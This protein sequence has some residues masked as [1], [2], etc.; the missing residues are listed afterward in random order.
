MTKP[1]D[2]SIR[3]GVDSR[4]F[5]G[6]AMLLLGKAV[7]QGC[8][9]L[10]NV[11]VA[12]I[13]GVENFGI[14]STF[15][16]TVS[17]F[18]ML[19]SLSVDRLLVQAEDGNDENF[20]ATAH[21]IQ[22]LR[23]FS[24]GLLIAICAG[25]MAGLFGVPQTAWAFRYLG[26]LPVLRGFAHLDNQRVQRNLTYGPSVLLD[27]AQQLIPT[28]LAWPIS[29]WTKD[30]SAMLWLVLLQGLIAALGSFAVADRPYRWHWDKRYVKRFLD[31]G[32]PLVANAILLFGIYQGDRFL[33]GTATKTLGS[34]AYSM[35]DLGIYA[36]ATSLTLTPMIAFSTI[37]SSL[38][39]PLFSGL[40]PDLHEFTKRYRTGIQ[41]VGLASGCFAV[42]LILAGGWIVTAIYGQAYNAAGAFIGWM[43]AAQAV[44]MARFT[45]AMGAMALG[46]TSNAMYSNLIR[47]SA[48]IGTAM[49]ILLDGSLTWIAIAGFIGEVLSLIV[50]V[51]KL[52][53]DHDLS[54]LHGAK[55]I[56]VLLANMAVAA[57]AGL[58]FDGSN[59]LVKLALIPMFIAVFVVSLIAVSPSLQS[60][61]H[62]YNLSIT[63]KRSRASDDVSDLPPSIE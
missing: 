33:I 45:P 6:G 25:P 3:F 60:V 14:A 20:Q 56:V 23:G 63:G 31:F 51:F 62:R 30:Y 15:A 42:P 26:L 47:F 58:F 43:A 54:A 38:M 24:S 49:V 9:F 21:A 19:G 52:Q 46:D 50:C 4:L 2:C 1:D 10:R 7:T 17:I 27:V 28:L 53:K 39:L 32:W 57:L 44:R 36:A 34:T 37:C 48:L 40:P 29:L 13:I 5:R 12:R 59:H 55:S 35:K 11:I 18:E 8:S 61:I 16:I 41:L 22:V